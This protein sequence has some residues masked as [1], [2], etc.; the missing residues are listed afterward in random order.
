MAMS[1]SEDWDD[2]TLQDTDGVYLTPTEILYLKQAINKR[3]SREHKEFDEL[4]VGGDHLEGSALIYLPEDADAL[5]A[6][7]KPDGETA[8]TSDD[9]G[10]L[11]YDVDL[12][13]LHYYDGT[14]W[15]PLVVRF[16]T[17]VTID[18]DENTLIKDEVY[19][20]ECDG[21]VMAYGINN[22]QSHLYAYTDM[23]GA[24]T[25]VLSSRFAVHNRGTPSITMPVRKGAYWKIA[26]PEGTPIIRWQPIGIGGCVKQ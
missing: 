16:G 13:E 3:I 14:D 4:G 21:F 24:T 10:R 8:L 1:S 6:L 12:G 9:K 20:A 19:Q 18:T 26:H 22:T 5:A 25:L 7:T 23:V 15:Q 2:S 17:M 11:A